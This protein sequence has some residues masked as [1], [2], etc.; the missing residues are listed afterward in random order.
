MNHALYRSWFPPLRPCCN[1]FIKGARVSADRQLLED[2]ALSDICQ[3]YVMGEG[4]YLGHADPRTLTS[5]PPVR[6]W[7]KA[8]S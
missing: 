6:A 8:K 2:R 7:D 1:M 4:F 5:P 3:V